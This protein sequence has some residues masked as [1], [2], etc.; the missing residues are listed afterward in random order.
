ML[1]PQS[2]GTA[3]TGFAI[4]GNR[5]TSCH[6]FSNLCDILFLRNPATG[7]PQRQGGGRG[8]WRR[9]EPTVGTSFGE[10]EKGTRHC[11]GKCTGDDRRILHCFR[12]TFP[13]PPT[14]PPIPLSEHSTKV[15]C[16][17]RVAG[18]Q[19]ELAV[20]LLRAPERPPPSPKYSQIRFWQ[21]EEDH[22]KFH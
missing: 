11:S 18:R 1:P 5:T 22:Q 20:H 8:Y 6:A 2:V 19:E 16:R 7:A 17:P 15:C 3:G 12:S 21:L 13:V 10:S 9:G 14:R 4:I